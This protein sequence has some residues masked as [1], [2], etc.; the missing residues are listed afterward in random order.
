MDV[1]LDIETKFSA[2]EVGGWFP[3][4]MGLAVAVTYDC[5]ND[6]QVWYEDEIDALTN[7]LLNLNTKR[8]IGY[9]I[10]DFDL[11]VLTA[12]DR[13]CYIYLM[14]KS[15]DIL[16]DIF[17]E[18][19][20]RIKLDDLA[21]WNLRQKKDHDGLLAINWWRQGLKEKV[22]DYCKNDV[23]L[24]YEL[25]QKGF[26]DGY[27]CYLDRDG[28]YYNIE[29]AWNEE[30]VK[31]LVLWK[32]ELIKFYE[33]YDRKNYYP[34]PSFKPRIIE[35]YEIITTKTP[36]GLILYGVVVKVYNNKP[37]VY[38]VYKNSPSIDCDEALKLIQFN[39]KYDG[40]PK[41]LV[42]QG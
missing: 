25:Y 36:Q 7:K 12:E 2:M 6:Y 22:V 38:G 13:S 19:G 29:L 39:S 35:E 15:L 18:L 28:N 33:G 24:T 32:K 34:D 41:F 4:K 42:I 14:S 21:Y 20:F 23:R 11:K 40:T 16:D 9:N 10:I 30:R 1:Y 37:V 8:I 5:E 26:K 31:N 17:T 27:L 3:E